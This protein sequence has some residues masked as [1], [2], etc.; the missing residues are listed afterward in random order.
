MNQI[1]IQVRFTINDFSDAIYYDSFLEY[2]NAVKD[3]SHEAEKIR[4]INN[5][6]FAIAN[7]PVPV[8]P[9]KQELEALRDDLQKQIDE[10]QSK[11]DKK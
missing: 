5:W 8:E 1:K 6:K 9:T 4:R 11:I 7:P 2:E 3:G 10:V